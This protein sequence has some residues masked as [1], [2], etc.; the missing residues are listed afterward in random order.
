MDKAKLAEKLKVIQEHFIKTL[1]K[2]LREFNSYKD[3]ISADLPIHNNILD[4][5]RF[6]AH[7]I[8]GSARIFSF[9]GLSTISKQLELTATEMLDNNN[10]KNNYSLISL[11]DKTIAEIEKTQQK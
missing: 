7:K 10:T 8:A 3:K 1:A 5:I 11:L 4:E 9:S 2:E 6:A